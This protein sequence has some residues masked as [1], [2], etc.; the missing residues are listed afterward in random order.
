MVEFYTVKEFS[1]ELKSRGFN[2]SEKAIR[3]YID[4]GNLKAQRD[5]LRPSR[6]LIPA[7]EIDRVTNIK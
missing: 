5:V 1:V 4:R 3:H 7:V 6:W 2:A